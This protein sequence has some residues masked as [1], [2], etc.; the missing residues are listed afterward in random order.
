MRTLFS[1]ACNVKLAFLPQSFIP[2][3]RNRK[4]VLLQAL[5]IALIG[6]CI[7]A[8]PALAQTRAA[9]TTNLSVTA[10]TGA[11]TTV[12]SGTVITLRASVSAGGTALTTGQV[13]FCDASA[14]YCTDIHLLGTAQLTTGGTATLRFRPGIGSHSYKAVFLGTRSYAPSSSS[15]ST[16]TVTGKVP[17][18]TTITQSGAIGAYTLTATVAGV[19]DSASVPGPTGTVS[20]VDTTNSNSLLGKAAVGPGTVGLSL[21]GSLASTTLPRGGFGIATA[22]FNGDGI[23]D[24]AVGA[25]NGS[26]AVLNILLG[27]GDG[28]FTA[29]TPNPAVGNYPYSVIAGDFN[30]D[31]I[32]DLA[33]GNVDDNTVSILLGKGDGTF[34]AMPNLTIGIALQSLAPQSLVTGDFNADGIPDLAVVAGSSVLVFIG[35][36]DGTFKQTTSNLSIGSALPQGIAVGDLNGDGIADLIVANDVQSG[37]VTIFIGN[38]DGTFKSG[39]EISGTGS[40]TIGIAVAD[41]NGDGIPDLAVTNYDG[42][43]VSILL[44]NGNGTFQTPVPYP[45]P[46][47]NLQ[48]VTAA[49]FNGDGIADL[50]IG[51]GYAG[52]AILQG[53]GDGTFG[54]PFIA[55]SVGSFYPSGFLAVADFNGDGLPDVAEPDQISSDAAV[56]LNQQSESVTATLNNVNPTGPGPHLVEA[57]YPGDSNYSSSVSGTTS[58]TVEVAPPVFSVAS[59]VYTTVQTVNITDTTPEATIYYQ[60]TG[61]VQTN[62]Y[63]QY[64]GPITLATG[65]SESIQAYATESGYQTSF[66]TSAQYTLDLPFAPV[67]TFSLAAGVYPGAQTVTISDS[68]PGATIYYTTNGLQPTVASAQYTGPI[69]VSSSE[70][71]VATAI[72]SGYSMSNAASAQYLI[73][74]ASTPF[75]YTVAGNDS[76]GYTGDGGPATFADLN[77]PLGFVRDSSGNIYIADTYNNLVRK[78]AAGTGI[79]STYAGNGTAGYS[80]D[81]G[82]ATSAELSLPYAL[83]LDSAGNL[84]ISDEINDV[85]R[86]VASATGIITTYAG[87]GQGAYGGDNGPATNAAL[88]LPEGLA[89][90][91]SGNLFIADMVN[92]RIRRVTASS[93]IITTVAGTG[94]TGYSGDGGPAT[95]AQ[96]FFPSGVAVDSAGNL[97]IADTRN[98]VIRKVSASNQ[99]ISTVAGDGYGATNFTGG[100]TG[101]GGPATSA[102]LYH[103]DAVAVDGSGNL[104][105]ADTYNQ[106]IREAAAGSGVI[107]TIAGNGPSGYCNAL[108]GDGGPALSAT[109]CY[110]SDLQV[111]VAGNVYVADT[112]D[113]RIR[114]VTAPQV[115][116]TATTASPTF[117][118]SPGAYASPQTVTASDATPGAS[119]YLTLN[120]SAPSSA[121]PAYNGPINVSGSVTI[122]A[123]A[124]ASGHLPSATTSATYTITSP[125]ASTIA[126]VAGTGNFA[127]TVAGTPA[128]SA[129]LP[130]LGGIAVDSAGDIYFSEPY[131][132]SVWEMSANTGNIEAVAGTGF[133]G[134][135]SGD[136]G[137]A[138]SAQLNSPSGLALDSAGN[139][140]IA[141]TVNNVIREVAAKTGIITTFARGLIFPSDVALDSAGNLYIADTGHAEIKMVSASTGSI[142]VVAGNGNFGSSGDGGPATSATL[143]QPNSIASD[144]VGNLYISTEGRIRKVTASTGIITTIAGN[145]NEG[146]SGDVTPATKAEIEA[147]KI[148]V[149]QAG[150][151][152]FANWPNGV[153][154]ISA[155]TGIITTVAGNG[156]SLYGGDGGSATIAG[157]SSP[158]GIAFD[159]AGNLYIADAG[160]FRIREV[161][162]S[163]VAMPVFYPAPGTYTS[164]Q[165]VIIT[166]A[167]Q[168]S[169]IYY[170][171]D[172]STP[173]TSSSA[174]SGPISVSQSATLKAIAV[175]KGTSSTVATAT[176]TINP[177]ATLVTPTVTVQT[178]SSNITTAQSLTVTVGVSGSSGQPTPTGSV[179]LS[180]G[181]YS[182]QQTLSS[183]TASFTIPAGTLSAGSNTLTVAYSGDST[184][185]TASGSATITVSQVVLSATSPSAVSP[186]SS[187]AATVTINAGS[188]Y[189]GTMNLTCALAS[190]PSGAQSLPTCSLSPN[191]TTI[192]SG[193]NASST[194]TIKTTA[195]STTAL[196]QPSGNLMR[197]L[198]GEGAAV[199]L[200]L[201]FGIPAKHRRWMSYFILIL[202]LGAGAAVVGCGGGGSQASTSTQ[203]PSIPATT[204]GNYTF[205]VTATDA[206][207]TS[208]TASSTVTITVE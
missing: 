64:T 139:L 105:I 79:I 196:L 104:Y 205:T 175:A 143:N 147:G 71:L 185:N 124:V 93:G 165:T 27:N 193:G 134:G 95:S 51:S 6:L 44:G 176:Y 43:S 152:Y 50:A 162:F 57:S 75:I 109:L 49:D 88:A 86:K 96:L 31:G 184:Y 1:S 180:S 126:T 28:T 138:T 32:P 100:Y 12:T 129:D 35:N 157:I 141:D 29:V 170:T 107:S 179:T 72:A 174:Y 118:V 68:V 74:T 189:S 78:V 66:G 198:G 89:V 61:V 58:L 151:I 171:A 112:S 101:D 45:V 97:Y 113:S 178:S 56:F 65:G 53:K 94:A 156:Y 62:G 15:A 83:A 182:S 41:F 11:V 48:S 40:G 39:S 13:N 145:G 73:T 7:G 17:T 63:V 117:S 146:Y 103:P 77:Y 163:G 166:G 102:E 92:N 55:A 164:A 114:L 142:A 37:S 140:Y 69:T 207:N 5:V 121:R 202:L 3:A 84:Y 22:D 76:F 160:D 136:G 20:F 81:G 167:T 206:T 192:S 18:T 19:V 177:T 108:G 150:N 128:A 149:D 158:Q 38:G 133:A 2:R 26:P 186:G 23:P 67:P 119:I 9:T 197:W 201:L 59:G 159:S 111:D 169:L 168:A 125:P 130:A 82:P 106:V 208:I 60:A 54:S 195:G 47:S 181:V 127:A 161:L 203:P 30:G 80:G 204:A 8:S 131:Y 98:N 200:V 183:G 110:P 116:P 4:A 115:P 153:R 172:G 99:N 144:S 46:L 154:E 70:T 87:N 52:V 191:S 25:S 120:G 91:A 90:D 14:K 190:S 173:T 122:T 199:A 132:N 148:A 155:G 16:L 187:T 36:G 33:V 42:D 10:K 85:I 123:V 34:T 21:S 137:P 24:L 135:Y 194:L 188:T